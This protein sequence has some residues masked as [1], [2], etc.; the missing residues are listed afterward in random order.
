[1][2]SKKPAAQSKYQYSKRCAGRKPS[3]AEIQRRLK[4]SLPAR[5]DTT[6]GAI[7]WLLDHDFLSVPK[8]CCHCGTARLKP[9]F[10]C[11]DRPLHFRCSGWNACQTRMGLFT[12]SIFE[13][14]RVIP[15]TLV[16][17]IFW[18]VQ[19]RQSRCP[20]VS[21]CVT[22]C[23]V[24]RTMA[25]HFLAVFRCLEAAAG[26]L[27]CASA[28]LFG[29]VEADATALTK[30][31]VKVS[32]KHYEKQIKRLRNKLD[33]KRQKMPKAVLV[34]VSVLGLQPR[35]SFPVLF[36]PPPAVT[37]QP[38]LDIYIYIYIYTH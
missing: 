26:K 30:F 4:Q 37:C 33:N 6:E 2:V 5:P 20:R 18:Y 11:A 3:P 36:V 27:P 10:D 29:N 13:G 7:A 25:K 32:N 17:L 19:C 15:L 9:V 24:G 14:L 1:M 38:S 21:D 8:T 34:H 35:N 28:V 23:Q 22:A 16:T 12:G 31:Y